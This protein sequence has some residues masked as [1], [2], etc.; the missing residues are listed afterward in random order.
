MNKYLLP[1]IWESDLTWMV[2]PCAGVTSS[3]GNHMNIKGQPALDVKTPVRSVSAVSIQ[4]P[5]WQCKK[6][7]IYHILIL[8]SLINYILQ[9]TKFLPIFIQTTFYFVT[10]EIVISIPA[11]NHKF[12]E[13]KTKK[14]KLELHHIVSTV[15]DTDFNKPLYKNLRYN[16][17]HWKTFMS[18][19]IMYLLRRKTKQEKHYFCF[20]F[21]LKVG[22][23][24]VS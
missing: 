3:E 19:N 2:V 12:Q 8:N 11:E 14:K 6:Y 24:N 1:T 4:T 13:A 23:A 16:V 7:H 21:F 18:K 5:L 17:K 22:I 9:I 20:C 15:T 10:S